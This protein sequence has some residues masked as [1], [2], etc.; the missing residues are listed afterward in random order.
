MRVYESDRQPRIVDYTR[1]DD[2]ATSYRV[3]FVTATRQVYDIT[4][5]GAMG[6]Q[7]AHEHSIEEGRDDPWAL[8]CGFGIDTLRTACTIE[9]LDAQLSAVSLDRSTVVD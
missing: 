6:S 9:D 1:L 7:Y 3:R 5:G 8:F 2:G 4:V